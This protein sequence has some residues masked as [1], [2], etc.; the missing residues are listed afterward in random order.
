MVT[1]KVKVKSSIRKG[2][3]VKGYTREQR[4]KALKISTVGGL[5]GGAVAGNRLGSANPLLGSVVGTIA[6]GVVG[7]VGANKL[8]SQL[9]LTKD[10]KKAAKIANNKSKAY[11]A[12]LQGYQDPTQEAVK[13]GITNAVLGG[14]V[15]GGLS[16]TISDAKS[17]G[18]LKTLIGAGKTK[19]AVFIEPYITKHRVQDGRALDLRDID[20]KLYKKLGGQ[21]DPV[22]LAK[23]EST[24][25]QRTKNSPKAS[26][27]LLGEMIDDP[28]D[29]IRRN[30]LAKSTV[31][32]IAD[33]DLNKRFANKYLGKVAIKAR[34]AAVLGALGYGTYSAIK[35]YKDAD[36]KNKKYSRKSKFISNNKLINFSSGKKVKVKASIRK[37]KIVKGYERNQ[38]SISRGLVDTS[39]ALLGTGLA[40]K[41][42]KPV[43]GIY[44]TTKD[45]ANA[46]NLKARKITLNSPEVRGVREAN[47]KDSYRMKGLREA[48]EYKLKLD[49]AKDIRQVV[50]PKSIKANNTVSKLALPDIDKGLRD[51]TKQALL[52]AKVENLAEQQGRRA[53]VAVR[54][55]NQAAN[56]Y[57]K[58]LGQINKI[59]NKV[60]ALGIASV[61]GT[62][63]GL[64]AVNL[65]RNNRRKKVK[66]TNTR[67]SISPLITFSRKVGS[68]DKG[69][70]KK[71]I[72][73]LGGITAIGLGGLT[74]IGYQGL[75]DIKNKRNLIKD[76]N[77]QEINK[78]KSKYENLKKQAEQ[79]LRAI[80]LKP[81]IDTFDS[82][83][84]K[85]MK[86]IVSEGFNT[87]VKQE[88]NK[89]RQTRR[90]LI[91]QAKQKPITSIRKLGKAG[92]IGATVAGIGY[93]GYSYINRGN[94]KNK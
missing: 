13:S 50:D 53:K 51:E 49:A 12:K 82:A 79:G 92:L 42:I 9:L 35:A 81:K 55:E 94:K 10:Q 57:V 76:I 45:S 2:R 85:Q 28:A 11:L 48:Y 16:L 30:K 80:N 20:D 22:T 63:V 93:G 74:G 7:T 29:Y 54:L 56:K 89:G 14:T 68:K 78:T 60:T 18:Y 75:K 65:I 17:G 70:R 19:S 6:G 61:V 46:S 72:N 83:E 25:Y 91:Q 8:G 40:Y 33:K 71:R 38:G 73:I 36:N 87:I 24:I 58:K 23:E 84:V 34:K 44:S 59:N 88:G 67:Y 32:Q 66:N 86:S 64:G 31:V 37:G 69:K 41:A 27:K 4:M 5:V 52:K 77:S 3:V 39:A 43:V 26:N 47:I 21:V 1:K 90:L 62:I 15:A